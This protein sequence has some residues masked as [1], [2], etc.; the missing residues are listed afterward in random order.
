MNSAD[1]EGL[2]ISLAIY[3]AALAGGLAIFVLPVYYANSPTVI[4]NTGVQ[5]RSVPLGQPLFADRSHDPIPVARLQKPEIVDPA[6]LAALKAYA[7]A[8]APQQARR[9]TT[10]DA[11]AHRA[12]EEGGS[13]E[14]AAEHRAPRRGFFPFFGLF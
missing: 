13:R 3:L 6:T 12:R 8:T 7:K 14:V 11:P 10:A 1:S 5:V 4:E 9:S 2:G